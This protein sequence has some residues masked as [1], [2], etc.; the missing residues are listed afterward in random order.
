MNLDIAVFRLFFV[1][2]DHIGDHVPQIDGLGLDVKTA[3]KTQQLPGDGAATLHGVE[4]RIDVFHQFR[5]FLVLLLDQNRS[6]T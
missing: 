2:I 6:F 3:G 4:D 5:V 1:K